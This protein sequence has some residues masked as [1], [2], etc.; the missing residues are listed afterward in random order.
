M[1]LWEVVSH[2]FDVIY[3]LV[4]L[5]STNNNDPPGLSMQL[6]TCAQISGVRYRSCTVRV[7]KY[8]CTVHCWHTSDTFRRKKPDRS[9]EGLQYYPKVRYM[10]HSP[11]GLLG[12]FYLGRFVSR[13]KGEAICD[14]D[15][16][17]LAH[18]RE[19]S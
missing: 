5:N 14:T 3:V 17:A 15:S 2:W 18:Y 8:Y 19:H 9:Q 4:M 10:H 7:Q 11:Q 12:P 1:G 16:I 13:Q 6:Y